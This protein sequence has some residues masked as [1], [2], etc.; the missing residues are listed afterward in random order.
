MAREGNLNDPAVQGRKKNR[1]KFLR[2]LHRE[3]IQIVMGTL[4]GRAFINY[5][6]F[7]LLGL[8]DVYPGNDAGLARHEGK[9]QAAVLL[10]LEVQQI[11]PAQYVIML[12]EHMEQEK[13]NSAARAAAEDKTGDADVPAQ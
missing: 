2:R 9:R 4:E 5:V 8:Q 10:G 1:E 13:S 11:C 6:I 3:Q 7:D 12:Q